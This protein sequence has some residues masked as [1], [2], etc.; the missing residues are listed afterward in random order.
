MNHFI[1][2]YYNIHKLILAALILAIK[3][4]EEN[5]YH[6]IYYSKIGGVS[7]SELNFLE[8]E[9]LILIGYRLFVDTKLYD[10]Y[11]NDL[12]SLK[13][14]DSDDDDNNGEEYE[15]QEQEEDEKEE[16][17]KEGQEN[18]KINTIKKNNNNIYIDK[19]LFQKNSK[20]EKQNYYYNEINYQ[21]EI[22]QT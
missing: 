9:Y 12:M 16:Q 4:N 11:Y 17:I 1:L 8:S 14:D 10:K 22:I 19:S 18:D 7:L 21:R 5:Y 20:S 6:M 2:T 15:E 13:Y 3:Y